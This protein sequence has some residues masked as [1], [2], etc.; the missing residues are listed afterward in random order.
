MKAS[1]GRVVAVIT[2]SISWPD[3]GVV[4]KTIEDQAHLCG[5]SALFLNTSGEIGDLQMVI[6]HVRANCFII[7]RRFFV[8]VGADGID[9]LGKPFALLDEELLCA[10]VNKG[11]VI[12]SYML[13]RTINAVKYVC[14]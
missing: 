2:D 3:F 13:N 7:S 6:K 9:S 14:L 5:Y 4:A 12:P 11:I 1:F 8:R 10:A